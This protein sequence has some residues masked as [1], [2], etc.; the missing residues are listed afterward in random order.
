MKEIVKSS[1]AAANGEPAH[2]KFDGYTLDEIRY[3]RALIALQKE[4]SLN[5]INRSVANLQKNNPL[6]PEGAASSL[7]G[8]A[9]WVASRLVKGLG[10]LDYAMIGFTAFG[11]VRKVFSFFKRKK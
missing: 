4:F 7:S 3:Q 5:R 1:V 6:T 8:N 9:G 10:Y 2:V 11:T